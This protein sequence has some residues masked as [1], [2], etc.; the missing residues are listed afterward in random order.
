MTN[1]ESRIQIANIVVLI[2]HGKIDQHYPIPYS[3]FLLGESKF[4]IAVPLTAQ[5]ERTVLKLGFY[6]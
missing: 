1:L 6:F 3:L 4:V 5:L 2:A